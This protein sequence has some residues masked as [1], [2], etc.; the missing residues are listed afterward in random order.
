MIEGSFSMKSI[1]IGIPRLLGN[2]KLLEKSVRFVAH[3]FGAGTGGT[4]FAVVFDVSSESRPVVVQVD[5][6]RV[7]V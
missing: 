6:V 5:L 2:R 7:F 1:E 4:Q 3:G